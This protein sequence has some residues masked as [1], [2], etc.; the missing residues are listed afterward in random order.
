MKFGEQE[1]EDGAFDETIGLGMIGQSSGR[2]RASAGEAK[3]K[4]V[5][6]FDGDF[7]SS[8]CLWFLLF[9]SQ[10]QSDEQE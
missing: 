3:S 5:F 9:H 7:I 6:V 2:I 8:K 1:E 10:A 4:G